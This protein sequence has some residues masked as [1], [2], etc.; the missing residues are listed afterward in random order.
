MS[1]ASHAEAATKTAVGG[2]GTG[3]ARSGLARSEQYAMTS[4]ART[5][6]PRARAPNRVHGPNTER[7]LPPRPPA[8]CTRGPGVCRGGVSGSCGLSDG[9]QHAGSGPSPSTRTGL[10]GKAKATRRRPQYDGVEPGEDSDDDA[11]TYAH[12]EYEMKAS[13][14]FRAHLVI[15]G[16]TLR[17]WLAVLGL[18]V[19]GTAA[20]FGYCTVFKGG[21]QGA[22]PVIHA[23]N[24]PTKMVPSGTSGEAEFKADQRTAR[25]WLAGANGTTGGRPGGAA[26]S[27]PLCQ[28][29][30]GH[31]STGSVHRGSGYCGTSQ[32]PAARRSR[33]GCA[34]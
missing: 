26:R 33:S 28:R 27:V 4:M 25:R 14:G 16:A 18:A 11:E 32:L 31:G 9:S 24:S 2:S 15:R 1:R 3:S 21:P 6:A 7:R 17:R 19:V 23:D 22:P 13:G 8:R 12:E 10:R 30:S 34:P 29:H 20:A 5:G